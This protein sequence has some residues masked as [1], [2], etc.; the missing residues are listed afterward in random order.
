MEIKLKL[1]EKNFE[2]P[3]TIY[4]ITYNEEVLIQYMIDHYRSRFADCRIVIYDNCSTDNTVKIAKKN[5]CEV[6]SYETNN[7]LD[8][9]AYIRIKNNCWK[10][11]TTDW[12]LVGDLDELL[13]IDSINLEK[14]E[15][16][17]STAISSEAYNMV[18]L[19]N[20]YDIHNISWGYRV[21][22]YD[23]IL[24]FNKKYITE[25]NYRIGC[26]VCKPDGVFK[27]SKNKYY[28]RHYK[29]INPEY[30]ISRY[31]LF[32]SR[33]SEGNKKYGWSNKYLQTSKQILDYYNHL[34]NYKYL[35]D[36]S[37]LSVFHKQRKLFY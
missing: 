28:L 33:L 10:S 9:A 3:I 16:Q 37:G 24:L 21:S 30:T 11:A 34:R 31:K 29:F 2:T 20:N 26:H 35:E 32:S 13:D 17:K 22:V 4:K 1:I 5:D 6:I 12:V 18:N 23:K 7:K 14:E 27:P 25:I 36:L 8:D 19:K 15:R